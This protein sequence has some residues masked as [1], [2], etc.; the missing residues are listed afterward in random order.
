MYKSTKK[1]VGRHE[2]DGLIPKEIYWQT[3]KI[4][5]K[6]TNERS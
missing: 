4:R 3:G 2:T 1:Y 6:L 5:G